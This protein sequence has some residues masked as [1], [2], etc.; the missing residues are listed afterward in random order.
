MQAHI[1]QGQL[2]KNTLL[3]GFVEEQRGLTFIYSLKELALLMFSFTVATVL[4]TQY[5][6]YLYNTLT[7]STLQLFFPSTCTCL[8]MILWLVL[9]TDI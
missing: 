8:Y 7:S 5:L 1:L 3:L 9:F 6:R 4:S 2:L